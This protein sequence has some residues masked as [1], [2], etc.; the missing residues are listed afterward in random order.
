MRLKKRTWDI[1]EEANEGDYLS[2][3]FDIFILSLIFLNIVAVI[4]ETVQS[5]YSLS[6]KFFT[7][8]EFFSIAIFSF[9]YIARIWSAPA[10]ENYK[11]PLSG[12]LKFIFTPMMVIDFLAIAP[13]YISMSGSFRAIRVLR[14]FRLFRVIKVARYSKA[15]K[16]LS[17]VLKTKKEELFVAVFV[18][19]IL[20][21][22]SSSL[23]YYIENEKQ[24]IAFGSI[25][26][27]MWW[28]VAT[29]TTVGYGDVH[30]VTPL[31][32]FLASIIAVLGIALFALPTGILGSGFVEELQKDK[33]HKKYCPHCGKEIE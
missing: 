30:P 19:L 18:L 20:L 3:V 27:A 8:F 14:L 17:K 1:L 5:I 32:K 31:G 13:F 21:V 22:L 29:L 28:S 6:P 2:R 9:E 25:P 12:R 16:T 10:N 7:Y 15:V 24:P 33:K 11:R 23:M 4:L 26:E